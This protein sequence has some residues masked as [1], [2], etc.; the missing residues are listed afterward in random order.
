MVRYTLVFALGILAGIWVQQY[1]Q[2]ET[3]ATFENRTEYQKAAEWIARALYSESKVLSNYE[4]IAWTIRN[5]MA[6]PEYPASAKAVVLQE[7]QFSAFRNP[8]KT[9]RL[10]KMTYPETKD[11]YFRRAYRIALYV[12][13]SGKSMNPMPEVT[14]FYMEDTLRDVHGKEK[15]RWARGQ[16]P[17]FQNGQTKYFRNIKSP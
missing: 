10:R 12:L 13:N 3:V 16:K 5:R 9:E 7:D 6:S 15:P 17:F 2:P 1:T 8:R 11:T 14:H 4:Y